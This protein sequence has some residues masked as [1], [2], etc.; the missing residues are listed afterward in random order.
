MLPRPDRADPLPERRLA[1]LLAAFLASGLMFL[2]APGTLLGVWNLVGISSA[3]SAG[4]V[5]PVW[6]QAH[7]HAQ[8]FGW[9]ATFMI[10]ISLY[11]V[12]KFRGGAVRSLAAGWAMWALWTLAVGA[13]WA[14]AL[15]AWHWRAVWLAAC[16]A[17]LAV[18]GLLIWQCA[19]PARHTGVWNRLIFS[20]FAG[21]FATL[22]WQFAAVFAAGPRPLIPDS[23][24]RILLWLALW[25]FAFPVAWGFSA[26]FLP[27]FLGLD[28]PDAR[29]ANAG[30]VCAAAS[31]AAP[32]LAVPAA[33]LACWSLRLFA[34]APR[35][36]KTLGVHPSYPVFA[37]LAYGWLVVSAA[38]ASFGAAP[39]WTGASRHAFTVGFLATL[40][41]ALGPRILP[42]FANS[43]ELWS[44]RLMFAA[45][46]LLTAGCTLRVIAE[47]LAYSGWLPFAWR[48][49]PFSALLE[50][51]A[52]VC[53]AAN[54]GVTLALPFPAWIEP[55][56]I[57]LDLTVYWCV[58]A[59]PRTRRVLRRAGIRSLDRPAMTLREAAAADAADPAALL[60]A[61]RAFFARRQARALREKRAA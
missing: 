7:G 17:E 44:S 34:R 50:L 12:P 8:L 52:V 55:G 56:S 27:A 13:R 42:S 6:I 29:A 14:S 54:L 47:P 33:L 48:V 38:L 24:N 41:F 57:T 2:V 28:K 46:L 23:D 32:V 35:K 10:G 18:A 5:P 39:G 40:I 3:R 15:T 37:R 21:L 11:T 53:F 26:R 4:S 36:A 25:T 20:G 16:S 59:Y 61:L 60:A 51:A 9:V 22:A 1:R 19:V 30:L 49:L 58:T 45:L 43:R 31:L